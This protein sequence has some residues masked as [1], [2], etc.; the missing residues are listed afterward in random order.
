MTAQEATV[1]AAVIAAIASVASLLLNT[2]LSESRDKRRILWEREL[3]RFFDLEEVAGRLVE[4]LLAYR[5]RT[6]EAKAAASEKLEYLHA[7]AGRFLRYSEV[8]AAL[9]ELHHTAGWYVTQD[10]KHETRQEFEQ[11]RKDVLDAHKKLLAACDAVLKRH[12]WWK[13]LF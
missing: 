13:K 8:A 5:C 6:E 9:R 1:I 12:P 3:N 10:M 7:A 4:D 2:R 11:T